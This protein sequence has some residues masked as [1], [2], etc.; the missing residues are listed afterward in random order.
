MVLNVNFNILANLS[1][2]KHTKMLIIISEVFTLLLFIWSEDSSLLLQ[3]SYEVFWQ[4]SYLTN[5]L[6]SKILV[7]DPTYSY[8]WKEKKHRKKKGKIIFK[9]TFYVGSDF[10]AW[11]LR[12]K[13]VGLLVLFYWIY[14]LNND[15]NVI[16]K[17]K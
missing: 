7:I 16:E 9:K 1:S 5:I 11:N 3:L 4:I 10:H 6:F 14:H 2:V 12:C 17:P 8:N 13:N 15:L